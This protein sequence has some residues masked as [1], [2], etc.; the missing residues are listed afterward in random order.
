MWYIS[1]P[2]LFLGLL[3]QWSSA[4]GVVGLALCHGPAVTALWRWWPCLGPATLY[5]LP[6]WL[7]RSWLAK[8]PA[9]GRCGRA[10]RQGMALK[11]LKGVNPGIPCCLLLLGKAGLKKEHL[12]IA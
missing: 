5:L 9:P 1:I 6:L 3:A 11:C 12:N 2:S 4:V 7:S 8:H 10:E